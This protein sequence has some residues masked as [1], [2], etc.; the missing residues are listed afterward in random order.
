MSYPAYYTTNGYPGGTGRNAFVIQMFPNSAQAGQLNIFYYRLPLRVQ[1]PV[2]NPAN[3][4]TLLDVIDGWDDMIVDY[5]QMRALI[6]ARSQDWQIAQQM[7][8]SKITNV[9][10]Q[11]R[12]FHD[13]PQ[14]FS[15]DTMVMPWAY[16]SW[17]GF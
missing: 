7:Y 2:A 6:K 14:Y 17:G 10:D 15:Y 3:Y 12:Q 13:Q 11:T 4:D 1:D 8:E 16:D 9:I 5:A